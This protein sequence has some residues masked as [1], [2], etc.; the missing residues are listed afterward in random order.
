MPGVVRQ[1]LRNPDQDRMTVRG[2]MVNGHATCHGGF[3]FT[4]AD[5]AFAFAC[6]SYNLN[7]VASGAAIEFTAPVDVPVVAAPKSWLDVDTMADLEEVAHDY[8]ARTGRRM[9]VATKYINLTRTFFAA[10]GVVDYRIVESAGATE[11]APAVGTAEMIV[12]ITTTG[13][14]L[15]ANGL[16]VLD[17]GVMA[18]K[19]GWAAAFLYVACADLV[20]ELAARYGVDFEQLWT[21]RDVQHSGRVD[22]APLVVA[23]AGPG[24]T[25]VQQGYA[26]PQSPPLLFDRAGAS[27]NTLSA[28][29][30]EELDSV[31]AALPVR[32][33]DVIRV[34]APGAVPVRWPPPA[35]SRAR[36]RRRRESRRACAACQRERVPPRHG[37]AR[38]APGSL[39]TA[40]SA[41][42]PQQRPGRASSVHRF[43]RSSSRRRAARP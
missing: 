7:T 29:V 40:R 24:P 38:A 16:K 31:L 20:P 32:A 42:S 1:F 36:R 19:F 4:L 13:A 34:F 2:D 15:A 9:R 26:T 22:T 12:D 25:F 39:R 23:T 11:G 43:P 27:A 30:I 33:A 18:G 3:I 37:R 21:R 6:N 28:D 17:D 35:R 14:T 5:S 41:N 10:H 8:L